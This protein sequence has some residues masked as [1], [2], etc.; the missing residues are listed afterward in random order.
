MP[1]RVSS[2]LWAGG[3]PQWPL[4][5]VFPLQFL[6]QKSLGTI[7]EEA[8]CIVYTQAGTLPKK[9]T[10]L[11]GCPQGSV[12][13]ES[14]GQRSRTYVLQGQNKGPQKPPFHPFPVLSISIIFT[15]MGLCLSQKSDPAPIHAYLNEYLEGPMETGLV[16]GTQTQCTT[17]WHFPRESEH[18]IN[19]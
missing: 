7:A 5:R 2:W 19:R 6:Q 11:F 17:L 18:I 1:L 8:S 15:N 14:Q 9:R 10:V 16:P 4:Q 3:G 12:F 13:S